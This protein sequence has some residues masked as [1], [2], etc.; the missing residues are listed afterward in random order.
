MKPSIVF[1]FVLLTAVSGKKTNRI[2]WPIP[3]HFVAQ[4]GFFVLQVNMLGV[5]VPE[6]VF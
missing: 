5:A 2:Y 6:C 3:E 4:H 1:F